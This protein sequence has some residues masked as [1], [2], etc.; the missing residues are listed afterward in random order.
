MEGHLHVEH[1]AGRHL[2]VR[3]RGA[4]RSIRRRVVHDA[5]ARVDPLGPHFSQPLRRRRRA[6]KRDGHTKFSYREP[7]QFDIFLRS[8][9]TRRKSGGGFRFRR[10]RRIR[11][12]VVMATASVDGCGHDG[13]GSRCTENDEHN[14][15]GRSGSCRTG[16]KATAC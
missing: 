4:G 10:G 1:G 15:A 6:Y 8:Q 9:L 16:P 3:E 7:P 5:A 2:R 13:G 14:P 12:L 11:F